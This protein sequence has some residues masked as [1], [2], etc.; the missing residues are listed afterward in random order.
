VEVLAPVVEP[1]RRYLAVA[2]QLLEAIANGTYAPGSR[3]P[4]DREIAASTRVSR[5]TVREALLALEIVGVVE[6][7]PGAGVFVADG[8]AS[9]RV[10]SLAHDAPRE[11]LETRA[12]IE[13]IVAG[14]CA[15]NMTDAAI[16]ELYGLVGDCG[17]ATA[18]PG[19]LSDLSHQGLVFHRQLALGCGNRL[20]G[21]I[22]CGLVDLERHPLWLLIND[23]AL[24]EQSARDLQL[25]E[26]REIV[27][28]IASRDRERAS[29]VMARHL[30]AVRSL[31]FPEQAETCAT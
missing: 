14:L 30:M 11:L 31:L 15:V 1:R 27:D 24:R 12:S 26:H 16:E 22:V 21:E 29:E 2:E 8:A 28:A 7:Q 3:I 23:L 5:P 9:H 10:G 4:S 6:V 17:H 25:G 20:L 18:G 13:P 19:S